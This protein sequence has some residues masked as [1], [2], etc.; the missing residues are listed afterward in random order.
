MNGPVQTYPPSASADAT[1]RAVRTFVIG[2]GI[3]VG[4]AVAAMLV[5]SLGDVVWT[6]A[7]WVALGALVGKTVV[8]SAVSY[9]ARKFAP[10]QL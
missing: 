9:F 6:K 10:P 1:N 2:L 5:V 3:D 7:Y 4:T 8:A